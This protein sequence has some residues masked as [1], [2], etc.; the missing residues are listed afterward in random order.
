MHEFNQGRYY[1]AGE[2]TGKYLT[3]R[4]LACARQLIKGST[5]K[6]MAKTLEIS[7][8]TAEDYINKLKDKF[9][10]NTQSELVVR[11]VNCSFIDGSKINGVTKG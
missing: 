6:I 10:I 11:L 5:A 3:T 4:E 8:R 7:P 2:F 1:L 9:G